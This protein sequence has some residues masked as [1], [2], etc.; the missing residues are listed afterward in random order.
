MIA[1]LA[2][3]KKEKSVHRIY[4]ESIPVCMIE[5]FRCRLI[6][7]HGIESV[8]CRMISAFDGKEGEKIE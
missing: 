6:K 8:I 4:F 1:L 2:N 7:T 3:L 5:D